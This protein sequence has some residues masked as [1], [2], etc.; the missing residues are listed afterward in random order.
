MCMLVLT[1]ALFFT[2][3][4]PLSS[5]M[6]SSASL[7][8]T[9]GAFYN[10]RIE[11][12]R[13]PRQR[14]VL[15]GSDT[16]SLKLEWSSPSTKRQVVP[17]AQLYNVAP[18]DVGG[19]RLVDVR[20]ATTSPP[21]STVTGSGLASALAGV[22]T[23]LTFV[24]RDRF[25]NQRRNGSDLVRAVARRLASTADGALYA[26][27]DASSFVASVVDHNDGSYWVEYTAELAGVYL[28]SITANANATLA[29][30]AHRDQGAGEVAESLRPFHISGS[31]FVVKIED[32]ATSP[33]ASNCT[34]AASTGPLY[35]A[36]AGT[37]ASFVLQLR[38][39]FGNAR[40]GVPADATVSVVAELDAAASVGSADN[41]AVSTV[42]TAEVS[43]TA[44]LSAT[45]MGY[46]TP[47]VALATGD[48][49]Y[50]V[51]YTA[52]VAGVY[53]LRVM[54]AT[55]PGGFGNGTFVNVEGSPFNL[56]VAPALPSA[57][58]SVAFGPGLALSRVFGE[59]VG[60]GPPSGT[61][62]NFTVEVR[63]RFSNPRRTA[64]SETD[65]VRV[66]L[67]G[68]TGKSIMGAAHRFAGTS[69]SRGQWEIM[70]PPPSIG[71]H[72]TYRV[73][74]EIVAEEDKGVLQLTQWSDAFFGESGVDG[75]KRSLRV[76]APLNST[77]AGGAAAPLTTWVPLSAVW[78]GLLSP[79]AELP[80]GDAA[81]VNV[82]VVVA[83]AASLTSARLTI[84]GKRVI[85]VSSG[86]VTTSDLTAQVLMIGGAPLP[87]ELRVARRSPA[88]GGTA[89]LAAG[90]EWDVPDV[91][92]TRRLVP[93]AALHAATIAIGGSPF[94]MCSVNQTM[95]LTDA[96][97]VAEVCATGVESTE[98]FRVVF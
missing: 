33:S 21:H 73:D 39:A 10:V 87:L 47:G 29:A 11:F 97:A 74:I 49:R 64:A 68:A 62:F 56:A 37:E 48:G 30:E 86:T 94:K 61:A 84:G 53:N 18:I 76:A 43:A 88:P 17:S 32:G 38:D 20:P 35:H 81:S 34:P 1:S 55:S 63:D 26:G 83:S 66:V 5:R 72:G 6:T 2:Q 90:L 45:T 42:L 15:E 13:D 50:A 40:A 70:Y 54:V 93:A 85:D 80:F 59:G 82:H 3:A 91:R 67:T 96:V 25:G 14:P 65:V 58:H 9:A 23:R 95:D 27:N 16:P 7:R 36:V 71:S 41:A 31:P 24:A 77:H 89:E 75:G 78:T 52:A 79:P 69:S 98:G 57:A 4:W 44:I 46:Q 8:L 28:L 60:G 22:P 51:R 19:T 92:V 12:R